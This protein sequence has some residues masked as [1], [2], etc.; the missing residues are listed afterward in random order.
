MSSLIT[1]HSL[2]VQ[3][4]CIISKMVLLS[5]RFFFSGNSWCSSAPVS[6]RMSELLYKPASETTRFD[7]FVLLKLKYSTITMLIV[8]FQF[9]LLQNGHLP[10]RTL[11][12]SGC[13]PFILFSKSVMISPVGKQIGHQHYGCKYGGHIYFL[14]IFFGYKPTWSVDKLENE[15]N[16]WCDR[17]KRY[18]WFQ[19]FCKLL[20]DVDNVSRRLF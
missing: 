5:L 12:T 6:D 3:L 7:L 1:L 17:S 18:P 11:A 16:L 14:V 4:T 8:Y 20:T 15:S 10:C 2:N 19:L 13:T 9:S